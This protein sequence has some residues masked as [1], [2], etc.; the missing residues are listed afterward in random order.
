MIQK[1][2]KRASFVGKK[3]SMKERERYREIG[4]N[5]VW[6]SKDTFSILLREKEKGVSFCLGVEERG[7]GCLICKKKGLELI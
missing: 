2:E 7:L 5:L 4:K 1:G 3:Y 6:F